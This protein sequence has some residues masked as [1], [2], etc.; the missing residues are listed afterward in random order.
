MEYMLTASA[1]SAPAALLCSK[2]SMPDDGDSNERQ[3]SAHVEAEKQEQNGGHQL[4]NATPLISMDNDVSAGIDDDVERLGFVSHSKMIHSHDTDDQD[5][6]MDYNRHKADIVIN[7]QTY[8]Y[9][10]VLGFATPSTKIS[11]C[12]PL[13]NLN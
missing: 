3:T 11:S 13:A 10:F 6:P 2:I 12:L 5:L 1:M 8:V 4:A 7:D 9:S